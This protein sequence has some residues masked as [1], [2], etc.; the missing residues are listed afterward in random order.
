MQNQN[1]D[2]K[3]CVLLENWRMSSYP[4]Y[5]AQ[6]V[7]LT[8]K[9]EKVRGKSDPNQIQLGSRLNTDRIHQIKSSLDLDLDPD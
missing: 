8:S 3:L 7:I 5:S 1:L 9:S 2:L 6:C 4:P